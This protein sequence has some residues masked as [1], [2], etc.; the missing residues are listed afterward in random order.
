MSRRIAA[1][2][3]LLAATSAAAGIFDAVLFRPDGD[4]GAYPSSWTFVTAPSGLTRSGEQL[5]R[6]VSGDALALA[7]SSAKGGDWGAAVA[8]PGWTG[9]DATDHTTLVLALRAPDGLAAAALPVLYLEDLN[10]AKTAPRPLADWCG[11]LA[12]GAAR[13]LEIPLAQL[14]ADPG[15]ADLTRIKTVFLGQG[16]ADGAPHRLEITDL[17]FTGGRNLT[18]DDVPTLVVLGSST[19]AG[20]GASCPDSSWVGRIRAELARR[21]PDAQVVNL[22]IGGYTTY[23]LLPDDAVTPEGRPRPSVGHNVTRALAYRPWAAVINLPSNDTAS[24]VPPAEQLANF[25]ELARRFHAAGVL[26]WVCTTQP[27]N[28]QDPE[29]RAWQTQ[30]RDALRAEF[31]D[32]CLDFWS[33]VAAADDGVRPEVDSGDGVHLNDAGHAALAR[34]V[35]EAGVLEGMREPD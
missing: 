9:H 31:G 24:G 8:D 7:W 4:A 13:T 33:V 26:L 14:A 3:L 11:D 19:A 15:R 34:V 29:Q 5:P 16:K 20:A 35:R 1:L 32:R 17:R 27:R 2:L 28:F 21:D 18:G 23:H 30:A 10:N 22:A 12:P 6:T 25:R